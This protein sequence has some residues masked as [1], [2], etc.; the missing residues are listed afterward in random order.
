MP[1][2][3]LNYTRLS[4]HL[5]WILQWIRISS[6]LHVVVPGLKA[7]QGLS[8]MSLLLLSITPLFHHSILPLV[9]R[10]AHSSHGKHHHAEAD[11]EESGELG[12]ENA[13]P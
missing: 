5:Q 13:Q 1:E 2:S 10:L 11:G 9:Q 4:Q 12:P 8:S 7:F 3:K 6:G